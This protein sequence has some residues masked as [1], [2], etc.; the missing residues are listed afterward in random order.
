[1]RI[2]SRTGTLMAEV[3]DK[4]LPADT[5]EMVAID[6]DG[7]LLLDDGSIGIRTAQALAEAQEAGT[8]VVL[9]S[10]RGPGGMKNAFRSL[11][12]SGLHVAH[13]GAL[14]FDPALPLPQ[15]ICRHQPLDAD[16]ALAVLRL[17]RA[18][19]AD[20]PVAIALVDR[21]FTDRQGQAIQQ[22]PTLCNTPKSSTAK[23]E[24]L[25]RDPVTKIMISGPADVLGGLQMELAHRMAGQV[26][27][28]FSHMHLLQVVHPKADKACALDHVAAHYG[29][30]PRRVMVI[31]DAPNDAGMFRWAGLSIAVANAWRE[32]REAAHFVVAS[33]EDQGVAEAVERYILK[34]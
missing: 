34:K 31:G 21:V 17:A 2:S 19:Q 11:G 3:D 26:A 29:I 15:G 7:T 32:V 6:L 5:F 9:A 16:V 4:P 13:N 22:D 14:I 1:M 12:L 8:R 27:F 18:Y 10:G 24:T 23:L 33:N 25:L 20:I 30:D 28:A